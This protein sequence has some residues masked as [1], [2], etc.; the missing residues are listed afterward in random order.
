MNKITKRQLIILTLGGFLSYLLFGIYD[1]MRGATLSSLLGDLQLNYASGGTIVMGQYAGYFAAT[2]LVGILADRIGPKFTLVLAAFSLV[3]GVGGYSASSGLLPLI[4]FIFFIGIGLGSL[5]LGGCNIITA[6][7]QEK[8]GRYLN[9]LAAIAGCGA[10]VTPMIAG[11]FL[12]QGISWRV[13][14]RIFC[15]CVPSLLFVLL[16][17]PRIPERRS[18]PKGTKDGACRF[19][20]LPHLAT[21]TMNFSNFAYMAAEI[22]TASWLV[23]FYQNVKQFLRNRKLHQPF[24]FLH[25]Y[26]PGTPW[27]QPFRRPPW[28]YAQCAFC[29]CRRGLLHHR[30][31]IRTGCLCHP[32]IHHGLLLLYHLSD[33]DRYH[34]GNL[35][36][37]S[38]TDS[39]HLPG[40][41]R[42]GRYVRPLDRRDRKRS[43]RP[44]TW[45][46]AELHF[47]CSDFYFRIYRKNQYIFAKDGGLIK[48][49]VL[50]SFQSCPV[51]WNK[52]RPQ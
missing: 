16:K 1:S 11:L 22:G 29:I 35:R 18:S 41:R 34:F 26:Y 50:L 2:L 12:D 19:R 48:A 43:F 8:K 38:R 51:M 17:T 3:F 25:R 27:R 36:G 30:R 46:G 42:T 33:F 5:E 39:G 4:A 21:W 37:A 44:G 10:F 23:D 28:T 24:P 45:H 47:L 7:Y 52:C 14:Y 31:R 40:L 13:I 6:L 15:H 49:S 9:I 20:T 32:C